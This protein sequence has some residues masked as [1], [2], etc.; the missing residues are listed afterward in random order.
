MAHLF[1]IFDIKLTADPALPA[2][3]R[4]MAEQ[5]ADIGGDGDVLAAVQHGFQPAGRAGYLV[6]DDFGRLID[7]QRIFHRKRERRIPC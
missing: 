4:Q 7:R 6:L 5:I 2:V 3:D 1:H